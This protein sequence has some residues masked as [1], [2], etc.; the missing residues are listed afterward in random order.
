[1]KFVVLPA[2]LKAAYAAVS[3][4]VS[5]NPLLP[6]LENFLFTPTED[7]KSFI[8]TGS[9]DMITISVS[10]PVEEG[11]GLRPFLLCR[12]YIYELVKSLGEWPADVEI[13]DNGALTVSDMLGD[14]QF[15]CSL[16]VSEYPVR[17]TV[18]QVGT[19]EV[20]ADVLVQ[21]MLSASEF[22]E[23][24]GGKKVP[25]R[26]IMTNVCL[27]VR[28]DRV[29]VVASDSKKMYLNVF[30]DVKVESEPHFVLVKPRVV[31]A[32]A[33]MLS[34]GLDDTLCVGF[35]AKTVTFA[36]GTSVLTSNVMEGK[37]P[38]YE[39]VLP[40]TNNRIAVVDIALLE[41]AVDRVHYSTD[42]TNG[43]KI[44]FDG[45]SHL[46]IEAND[47]EFSRS[48]KV[49]IDTVSQTNMPKVSYGMAYDRLL[50]VLSA[51]KNQKNVTFLC[52]DE[53]RAMLLKEDPTGDL[54]TLLMPMQ[55]LW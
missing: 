52:G 38:R 49:T 24:E 34:R 19:F 10:L 31:K 29:N 53:H 50:T 28:Q 46:T 20:N 12:Q 22:T 9:D 30:A 6:V 21:A 27:D 35:T 11:S 23:S 5:S 48:A 18:S 26:P 45:A 2:A 37:F 36:L 16:D 42:Y 7:G 4:A 40:K 44:T 17:K 39:A 33:S 25:L 3:P 1:M 14:F 8:V 55:I 32:L 51:F 41:A 15:F 13:D 47:V 43:I 54:T